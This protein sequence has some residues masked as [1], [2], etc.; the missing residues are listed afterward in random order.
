MNES[1]GPV[2][3]LAR[4]LLLAEAAVVRVVDGLQA[5]SMASPAAEKD[6]LANVARLCKRIIETGASAH[7]GDG[8][9]GPVDW[10]REGSSDDRTSSIVG[11]PV[12]SEE[13]L[14]LGA[15][16]V[17]AERP[18]AWTGED[19]ENLQ[20][21]AR[22]A[23]RELTLLR[24]RAHR[25]AVDAIAEEERVALAKITAGE[26]LP[27][28][29]GEAS[30]IIE[31][32]IAG[33]RA[34][35]IQYG[36]EDVSPG[37][38]NL[39]GLVAEDGTLAGR[40]GEGNSGVVDADDAPAKGYYAEL[41][42]AQ[43]EALGCIE[44]LNLHETPGALETLAI[45]AAAR[46]AAAGLMGR[47]NQSASALP[48]ADAVQTADQPP[49]DEAFR[50]LVEQS[51]GGAYVIREDGVPYVNRRFGEIFGYTPSKIM[52]SMQMEQLVHPRDRKLVK[53]KIGRRLSGADFE[54]QY[55]FRGLRSDGQTVWCEVRGRRAMHKGK[56]AVLGML[57]DVTERVIAEQ[58]LRSSEAR[59]RSLFESAAA[60]IAVVDLYGRFLQINPTLERLVGHSSVDLHAVSVSDMIVEQDREG[61][62]VLFDELR[63][64]ARSSFI[65]ECRIRRWDGSTIIGRITASLVQE[66]AGPRCA[67]GIIQDITERRRQ[68]EDLLRAQE[69]AEEMVRLKSSFL[70]NMSHELRTPLTSIIG[71]SQILR[72][73]FR[74]EGEEFVALIHRSGQ[75]LLETLNAVLDLAQLESRS[76]HLVPVAFD[77]AA[78][79]QDIVALFESQAAS[80]GVDLLVRGID[81]VNLVIH[82]RSAVGRILTHLV[83]NA[84]KFTGEGAVHVE[85]EGTDEEVAVRISDSGCG[86]SDA[87]LPHL[88]T[89]FHQESSGVMRAHEGSGIGLAI[90]SRLIGLMGGD[91]D[92]QTQK[93]RGSTFNV[94]LPRV[95]GTPVAVV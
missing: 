21:L 58:A 19:R 48:E 42:G 89:E 63:E 88:F 62:R 43:G 77:L 78:E 17:M 37:S 57:L 29:L 36:V 41:L 66:P 85:V 14:V 20:L 50:A 70:A 55:T 84:I 94:R 40:S 82:D 68:E 26:P 23:E 38:S 46:I 90:A 67:I 31:R 69:R 28:I 10:S 71:F 64:G 92:V 53:L 75:R 13:G 44:V 76:M 5:V 4:R 25:A 16:C 49:F 12:M 32:H 8:A 61:L 11:V 95:F 6:F 30:S 47:L 54:T 24:E 73:D 52:N 81:D 2:L 91:I 27:S 56:P 18:R 83:S 45:Q 34:R 65:T 86:I 1:F 35:V 93:G 51:L 7:D 59:F 87:F 33:A 39:T 22:I 60:G 79:V 15:M 72:E 74:G 9:S 3:T 80:K